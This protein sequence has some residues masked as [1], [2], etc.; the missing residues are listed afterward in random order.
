MLEEVLKLTL[1]CVTISVEASLAGTRV[2][3]MTV[4]T[5]SLT[6]APMC[7]RLTLVVL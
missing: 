7:T 3:S 1:A 5:D 6:A 4:G 2:R